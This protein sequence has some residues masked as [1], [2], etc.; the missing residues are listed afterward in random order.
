MKEDKTAFAELFGQLD[1]GRK[2]PRRPQMLHF[3]S[4]KCYETRVKPRVEQRTKD[5]EKRA[6]Y[7]GEKLPAAITLQ[8]DVTK[9]CWEEESD[10]FKAEMSRRREREFL[11]TSKAW[12]ESAADGPGRTPEELSA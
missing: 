11:I 4:S 8:N 7:T 9:E 2:G 1:G 10:D 12:Q 3:Y 6:S 5:L